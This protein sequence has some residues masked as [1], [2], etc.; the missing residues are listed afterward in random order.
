[1]HYNIL[2]NW[3]SMLTSRLCVQKCISKFKRLRSQDLL[4]CL[5]S[6]LSYVLYIWWI[7]VI[8]ITG[9]QGYILHTCC[10]KTL[11][12]SMIVLRI[13]SLLSCMQCSSIG[14]SKVHK[15]FCSPAFSNNLVIFWILSLPFLYP[16]MIIPFISNRVERILWIWSKSIAIPE[17]ASLKD[18]Y[19]V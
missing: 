17:T 1:M 16:A 18:Q 19:H 13:E 10:L 11:S 3:S 4:G 5:I 12:C 9:V 2:Q 15:S 8:W 6:L 14:S 7:L